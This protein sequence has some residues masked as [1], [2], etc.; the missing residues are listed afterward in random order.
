MSP[1]ALTPST[2]TSTTIA[3]TSAASSAA[4]PT[5]SPADNFIST[6]STILDHEMMTPS[7]PYSPVSDS[8]IPTGEIK[9]VKATPMDFTTPTPIGQRID[10][11][12]GA[13]GGYDHTFVFDGD[14]KT[15]HLAARVFEP[16][17]G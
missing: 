15:S 2:D 16:Q 7:T 5:A 8:Y 14:G 17:S 6:A 3:P 4:A 9:S 1:S 11:L 12:T 10:Q 13:P